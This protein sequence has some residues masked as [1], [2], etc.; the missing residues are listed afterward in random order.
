MVYPATP[1]WQKRHGPDLVRGLFNLDVARVR[2]RGDATGGL[3]PLVEVYR[4]PSQP[5]KAEPVVFLSH[6]PP[7]SQQGRRLIATCCVTWPPQAPVSTA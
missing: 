6:L 5:D 1:R 4:L 2:W 3:Y 7:G